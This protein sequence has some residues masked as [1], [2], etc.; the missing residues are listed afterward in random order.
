MIVGV[1]TGEMRRPRNENLSRIRFLR[2]ITC[3]ALR[4][5]FSIILFAVLV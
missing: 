1:D 4:D 3:G 2:L 5:Q